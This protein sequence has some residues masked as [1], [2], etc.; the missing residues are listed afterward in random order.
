MSD[1][2][3]DKLAEECGMDPPY[4]WIQWKGTDV[5]MDTYCPCGHHGHIDAEFA[6]NYRCQ[7][8]D[9]IYSVSPFVRLRK[10][11]DED[12]AEIERGCGIISDDE[13]Q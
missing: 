4:G 7:K 13:E 9:T 5:C 8:C 12:R 1:R 6:Y 10:V 3:Y 2:N 11:D